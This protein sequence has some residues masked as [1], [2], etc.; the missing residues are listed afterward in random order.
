MAEEMTLRKAAEEKLARYRTTTEARLQMMEA[1]YVSQK[2]L[3][4]LQ[5]KDCALEEKQVILKEFEDEY[6]DLAKE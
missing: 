4:E 6:G 3:L 1:F 5:V 2:E